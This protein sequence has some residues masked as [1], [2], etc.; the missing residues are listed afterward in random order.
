MASLVQ[1]SLL[2]VGLKINHMSICASIFNML[3]SVS[4]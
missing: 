4:L 3:S 1:L 2:V